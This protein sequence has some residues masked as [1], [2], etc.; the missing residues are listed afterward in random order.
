MTDKVNTDTSSHSMHS[1]DEG[2]LE[3]Q[4][5]KGPCE[6]SINKNYSHLGCKAQ[7]PRPPDPQQDAERYLT[8]LQSVRERSQLVF[9]RVKEGR[10]VCFTM[11][12]G[13]KND[14][15]RYVVDIIKV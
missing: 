10:G 12:E 7:M 15:A 2:A 8:S 9:E 5:L 4:N 6:N 13:K 3:E 14:I 1:L 11:D